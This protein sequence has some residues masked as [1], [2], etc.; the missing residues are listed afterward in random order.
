MSRLDPKKL[1]VDFIEGVTPTEPIIPRRYTLTHS[2]ITGEL[3]L[4]IGIKY[5]Y[6]KISSMRDEVL[7]EW[8]NICGQYFFNVYLHVDQ[9]GDP[10]KTAIRNAIFIRELPLALEAIRYGD[11]KFFN[12]HAELD[13]VPIMV[14][15]N[16]ANPY[17]NRIENWGTFS[18]YNI[19]KTYR[20]DSLNSFLK[21]KYLL[22]M[23]LGD[24]NG[25]EIVDKVSLYGNKP[26]GE[27]G[28]FVDNITVVIKDGKTNDI[29]TIPLKFN[30]GYNPTLFLG[31]FT[32][33][34]VNDILINI[35]S[36]GSGGYGFFYIYS[37]L[38]NQSEKLFDFELFNDYYTYDVVYKDNYK[39]EVTNKILGKKFIID[40]S[41]KGNSY[42]MKIYY[43]NGKLKD[44]LYGSVS[45]INGLYPIDFQ[46]DGIYEL[47]AIQRIIGLYNADTLGFAQMPLR[48]NGQRF[49][50]VNL[51]QFV[52]IPGT[53]IKCLPAN[54]NEVDLTRVQC[55]NSEKERDVKLEKAFAK[56][57]NL[58]PGVDKIRYYYNRIDLDE[59]GKPETFVYLLGPSLC[60]TGGCSAAIFK[61]CNNKYE[62]LS[63]FSLV[64]NPIIISNNKTNGFRDIL[65]FV[66]GGGI[67]GFLAELKYTG[68]SYPSNPSVKPKVKPG[69]KIKGVAIIA[70]DIT[71]NPGIEF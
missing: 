6:D 54:Y 59:D 18:D 51:N 3:F 57:F 36:G 61:Q 64:N 32:G 1:S 45:A 52:A 2:D 53:D 63:K 31:D 30:A 35:D 20:I 15:F 69:T 33:D 68:T 7:G 9:P 12:T 66:S 37:F 17:F 42:L 39:V 4:T 43:P 10:M 8:M 71:S 23:K 58:K 24:V 16:S 67:E 38:D 55:M 50:A 26:D 47:S 28:I 40:I 49:V 65:M 22:D 14:H 25:D 46:R 13:K 56:A 60:G 19:K 70:D 44:P 5:A 41:N 34:K 62:L 21:D 29:Y 27:T 48:W 11:D